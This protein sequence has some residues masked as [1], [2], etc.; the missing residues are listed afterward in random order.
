MYASLTCHWR[1]FTRS[2]PPLVTV[3]H[4]KDLSEAAAQIQ[5]LLDQLSQT[6]PTETKKEQRTFARKV[7]EIIEDNTPLVQRLVNVIRAGQLPMIADQLNHP[8]TSCVIKQ[9][10]DLEEDA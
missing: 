10:E 5:A 9:L 6:Y 7:M 4:Q 3:A 8:A 1:F 2:L